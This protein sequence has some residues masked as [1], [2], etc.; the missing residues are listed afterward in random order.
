[1][2]ILYQRWAGLSTHLK[3]TQMKSVGADITYKAEERVVGGANVNNPVVLS[4]LHLVV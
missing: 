4:P 2:S 1:M 3:H